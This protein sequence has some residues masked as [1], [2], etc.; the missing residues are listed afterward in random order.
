MMTRSICLAFL[1]SSNF[2]LPGLALTKPSLEVADAIQVQP[3][4][5]EDN[6]KVE[7]D[8]SPEDSLAAC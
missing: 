1:G 4:E 6:S 3:G 5:A 8:E 2:A 7:D